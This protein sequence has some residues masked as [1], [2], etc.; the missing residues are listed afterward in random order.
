MSPEQGTPWWL[1]RHVRMAILLACLAA[2]LAGLVATRT[3]ALSAGQPP[4][5]RLAPC[6]L[7]RARSPAL[8]GAPA[9]RRLLSGRRA[10]A[11][12]APADIQP[13]D[14]KTQADWLG[15]RRV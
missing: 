2:T 6:S 7:S 12:R 11:Q 9:Q 15:V 4:A 3:H 1:R 13:A 10:A 8:T 5:P 14:L